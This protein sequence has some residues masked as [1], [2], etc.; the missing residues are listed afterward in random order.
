MLP[1]GALIAGPL[2][3]IVGPGAVLWIAI[4][5]SLAPLLILSFSRLWRLKTLEDSRVAA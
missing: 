5:G 1:I 4:A 2:A 3:E